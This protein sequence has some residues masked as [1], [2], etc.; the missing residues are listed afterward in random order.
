MSRSA[1][2]TGPTAL[3]L[4]IIS[5]LDILYLLLLLTIFSFSIQFSDPYRFLE[6]GG[7]QKV[8]ESF[9]YF[10]ISKWSLYLYTLRAILQ[11][12]YLPLLFIF[13][14]LYYFLYHH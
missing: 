1:G 5:S 3:F 12:W 9:A 8:L 2:S 14:I 7:V 6:E 10:P 4:K 13:S 11:V